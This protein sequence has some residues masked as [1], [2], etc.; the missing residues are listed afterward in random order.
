[1]TKCDNPAGAL[2]TFYDVSHLKETI[3]IDLDFG[4]AIR[5][6]M[7]SYLRR[8]DS[9][10]TKVSLPQKL[11]SPLY[12]LLYDLQVQFLFFPHWHM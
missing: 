7:P 8:Y 3:L 2:I 5:R 11:M 9:D 1:M 4:M 10:G 6:Q 12:E